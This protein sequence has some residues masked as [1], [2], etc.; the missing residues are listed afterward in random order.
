M[1]LTSLCVRLQLVDRSAPRQKRKR[2]A[3]T[4]VKLRENFN[5]SIIELARD[6]DL[7]VSVIAAAALGRT[8]R[9]AHDSIDHI[10]DA[11]TCLPD[12]TFAGAPVIAD[13]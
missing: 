11:L 3:A 6:D 1:H 8:R 13:H 2:V 5:A 4:L 7:G 12:S 10:L 9:E